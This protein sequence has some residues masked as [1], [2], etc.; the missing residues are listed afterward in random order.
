MNV[1]KKWFE[2]AKK[3]TKVFTD[4]SGQFVI[5]KGFKVREEKDKYSILDVRFIDLYSKVRNSEY[6]IMKKF[7]FIIGIDLISYARDLNRVFLY[8]K[9]VEKFYNLRDSLDKKDPK[10]LSKLSNCNDN[11]NKNIDLMFY[12]KT[13]INQFRIKYSEI[14]EMTFR[15]KV[16]YIDKK[17]KEKFNILK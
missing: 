17:F 6:K 5:Y 14:K 3:E 13:R 4:D 10:Y 2:E 9:K 12:Y 1:L 16:T 8:N 11:I 15:G 7:G